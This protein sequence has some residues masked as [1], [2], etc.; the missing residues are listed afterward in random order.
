MLK[1]Q[2]TEP[3][4]SPVLSSANDA[5]SATPRAVNVSAGIDPGCDQVADASEAD[6]VCVSVRSTSLNPMEP[7][8]SMLPATTPLDVVKISLTAADWLPAKTGA[9][10]TALMVTAMEPAI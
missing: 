7:D 5:A 8:A 6:T 1:F 4:P 2:S 10:L 9:S 3:V